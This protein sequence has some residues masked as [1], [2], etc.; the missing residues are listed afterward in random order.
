MAQII[1]VCCV[2]AKF[3][4]SYKIDD[5]KCTNTR[6][7]L[8]LVWQVEVSKTFMFI[9]SDNSINLDYNQGLS[10]NLFTLKRKTL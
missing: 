4:F 5:V 7:H 6:Q 3:N 9:K 2:V 8:S 1:K 10:T